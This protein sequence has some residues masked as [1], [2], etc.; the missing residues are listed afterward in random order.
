MQLYNRGKRKFILK[1]GREINAGELFEVAKGEGEKLLTLFA[2][3]IVTPPVATKG[4]D[5]AKVIEALE[6]ENKLL[7][8]EIAELKQ[9]LEAVKKEQ[10]K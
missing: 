4:D 2:N 1:D 8:D 9:E 10:A 6:T 5:K 3:E 7:K